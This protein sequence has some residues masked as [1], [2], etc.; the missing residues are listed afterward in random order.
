MG[1]ITEILTAHFFVMRPH[2]LR[3]MQKLAESTCESY[4]VVLAAVGRSRLARSE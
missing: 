1:E 3:I 2:Y 4:E